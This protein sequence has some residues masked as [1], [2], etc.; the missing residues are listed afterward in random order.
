MLDLNEK[1]SIFF[2]CCRSRKGAWIEI[3]RCKRASGLVTRRS[4]KGAW[5]EIHR[6][7]TH[8]IRANVAPARERGLKLYLTPSIVTK[9]NCR[10]RKGAWIE[11]HVLSLKSPR[12]MSLPQGSVDWN[13]V[14]LQHKRL[15]KR[16]SRKGAWIEIL[17]GRFC[18]CWNL[19]SLP[20]G[21]V[22][23]N[24]RNIPIVFSFKGRSRKGAWIEIS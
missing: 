7:T 14:P 5:I 8:S 18:S 20:Q 16:R 21:S 4:R 2:W 6:G 9:P 3:G 24:P 23:W 12:Y 17:S 1:R 13:I 19:W 15:T 22:D 10:S 11:I